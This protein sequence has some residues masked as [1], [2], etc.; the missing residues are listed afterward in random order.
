MGRPLYLVVT[1]VP[2]VGGR[3]AAVIIAELLAKS[4]KNAT[5]LASY[6]DLAP[7]TRQS[8]TSIRSERVSQPGNK[9]QKHALFLSAFAII[10]TVPIGRAY[11]DRNRNQGE[12]HNQVPITL[13]HGRR[14]GPLHN[15]QR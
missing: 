10:R 15:G 12:R 13:A 11:Y 3:T 4:F 6:T 9:H 5:A 14:R 1:S 8:G 7:T 2:G